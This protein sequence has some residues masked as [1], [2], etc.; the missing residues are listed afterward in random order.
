MLV[1]GVFVPS[2]RPDMRKQ[3]QRAAARGSS[4]E[5]APKG[6]HEKSPLAIASSFSCSGCL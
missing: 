6:K 3:R 2:L 5:A 4:S 1:C